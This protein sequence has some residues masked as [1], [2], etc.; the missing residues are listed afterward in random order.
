[1]ERENCKQAVQYEP[2]FGNA[3]FNR[4]VKLLN[5]MNPPLQLVCQDWNACFSSNVLECTAIA[6]ADMSVKYPVE[7]H[8][9]EVSVKQVEKVVT[10]S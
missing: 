4:A 3:N 7:Y 6:L 2:N 1:M 10:C 9:M 8:L 5:L